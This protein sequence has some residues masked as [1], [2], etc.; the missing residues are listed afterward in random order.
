M[1]IR[2]EHFLL[3]NKLPLLKKII[4]T[5]LDET[6]IEY[7][8]TDIINKFKANKYFIDKSETVSQ[9][10]FG[11]LFSDKKT[12]FLLKI[13]LATKTNLENFDLNNN[14]LL[15]AAP[16]S[17]SANTIKSEIL[18]KK[19]GLVI[20]CYSLNRAGK[21]AVI[22]N[23]ISKYDMSLGGD[24]FWYFVE[25]LNNE[26]VFLLEQLNILKLYG[27]K[28][29]S[30][31]EA[32]SVLYLE[33]KIEI[34]KIFFNIFKNNKSL[35]KVFN[36]NIYSQSDLYVFLKSIKSNLSLITKS[37]NK[38]DFLENFPKYLFVER[39]AFVKIYDVLD[40]KKI[41]QIYKNISKIEI[42]IRKFPNLY[43]VLGLRFLLN[44][45]KIIIS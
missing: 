12:L 10:S 16:N 21:E 45:K 33:N 7:V 17:K 3:N 36:T 28:I 4:I 18:K 2:A 23:F 26:Y 30:I 19:D 20:E 15:I 35:I 8:K 41:A 31:Q 43:S 9:N 38:K 25:N 39:D 37:S 40:N 44:M 29:K 24:I 34:G 5:G 1:K 22:R 6:L 13:G 11:D 32:E 14:A 42:L 27:N